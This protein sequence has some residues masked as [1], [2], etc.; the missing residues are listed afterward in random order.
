LAEQEEAVTVHE[1]I[2]PNILNVLMIIAV[3]IVALS[4]L[5]AGATKYPTIFGGFSAL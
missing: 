5:K 4:L 3:L 1:H 2:E